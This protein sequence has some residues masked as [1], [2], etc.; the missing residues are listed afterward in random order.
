MIFLIFHLCFL[1][2]VLDTFHVGSDGNGR[3]FGC[4]NIL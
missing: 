2:G 1:L 3:L 4:Q